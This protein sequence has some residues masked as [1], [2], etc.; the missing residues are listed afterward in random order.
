MLNDV[1]NGSCMKTSYKVS[2]QTK[3]LP[4]TCFQMEHSSW[5]SLLGGRE[6]CICYI[7]LHLPHT[8]RRPVL[9][10]LLVPP[11]WWFPSHHLHSMD[12]TRTAP[13]AESAWKAPSEPTVNHLSHCCAPSQA[14]SLVR[15]RKVSIGSTSQEAGLAREEGINAQVTSPLLSA[16][17]LFI[18]HFHSYWRK[19]WYYRLAMFLWYLAFAR[20]PAWLE[21]KKASNVQIIFSCSQ[22]CSLSLPSKSADILCLKLKSPAKNYIQAQS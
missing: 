6:Q 4:C 21:L 1:E 12:F 22:G 17:M 3:H 9:F 5:K 19:T 15:T 20:D 16:L 14:A 7:H 11:V 8:Y 10:C 18:K 2:W 13:T